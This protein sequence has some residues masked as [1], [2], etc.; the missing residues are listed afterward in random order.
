MEHGL[1]I[2]APGPFATVYFINP[3]HQS[4]R[5]YMHPLMSARQQLSKSLLILARQWPDKNV[6][7]AISTPAAIEELLDASFLF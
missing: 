5:L 1:Y 2:M 7:M 3:S 6:T 4:A